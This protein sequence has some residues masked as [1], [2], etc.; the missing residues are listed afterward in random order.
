MRFKDSHS[1]VRL[2]LGSLSDV[3]RGARGAVEGASAWIYDVVVVD[4]GVARLAKDGARWATALR[5]RP[6]DLLLVGYQCETK[7]PGWE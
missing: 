4:V 2:V 3:R 5:P 6:R 7:L 1:S